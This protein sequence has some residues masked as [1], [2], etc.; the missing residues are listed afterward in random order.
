MI[1]IISAFLMVFLDTVT[2]TAGLFSLAAVIVLL[3]YSR[4]PN[5][6]LMIFISFYSIVVDSY[7][8]FLIGTHF[9]VFVMTLGIY[10]LQKHLLPYDRIAIRIMTLF[11]SFGLFHILIHTA[12]ALQVGGFAQ[13]QLIDALTNSIGRVLF[14]S[15]LLSVLVFVWDNYFGNNISSVKVRV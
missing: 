2:T 1:T 11:V 13:V 6:N 3:V 9:I 8:G 10:S 12:I 5:H 4:V 14:E 7:Y 15:L